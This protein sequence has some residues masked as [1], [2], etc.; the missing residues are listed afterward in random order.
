MYP[1]VRR[2]CASRAKQEGWRGHF[3]VLSCSMVHGGKVTAC[4]LGL[5]CDGEVRN[6]NSKADF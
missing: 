3:F 5:A 4:D 2:R 1:N 6:A